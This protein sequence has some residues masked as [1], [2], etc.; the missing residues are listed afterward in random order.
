MEQRLVPA[1]TMPASLEIAGETASRCPWSSATPYATE[2]FSSASEVPAEQWDRVV[3][4]DLFLQLA[5]LQAIG[6]TDGG[7]A[8]A[9]G[10]Y[11]VGLESGGRTLT[12]RLVLAR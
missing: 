10:V 8:A 5:Y 3:G 6:A 2:V 11:L 4:D 9:S 12:R 1:P 7:A